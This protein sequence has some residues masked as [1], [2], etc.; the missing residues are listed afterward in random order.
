MKYT[1]CEKKNSIKKKINIAC[2]LICLAFVVCVLTLLVF[3]VKIKD[4]PAVRKEDEELV[5]VFEETELY[6]FFGFDEIEEPEIEINDD[7]FE[8]EEPIEEPKA[9]RG[10]IYKLG[11]HYL[12]CGSVTTKS[13][14][15][16][17]ISF[18]TSSGLVLS[19]HI[20]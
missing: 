14:T 1:F 17:F 16:P 8:F 15:A 19:P 4:T 13:A 3:W 10:E 7:D 6:D 11:N 20:K 5:S 2:D 12:M 18:S 9:K